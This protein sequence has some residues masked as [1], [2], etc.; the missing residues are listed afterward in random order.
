MFGVIRKRDIFA[1]PFVTVE[2]FGWP[3]FFRVL[4]AGR[5]ETFLSL[6]AGSDGLRPPT[7]EV[8]ELLGHCV[9]LERRARQIY[10]SLAERFTDQ[11]LVRQFFETLAHQEQEHY[12]M[13][14]LCRQLASKGGWLE[15]HFAPWRDAVPRLERQMEDVEDS[16]E[17]LDC[18]ADA[19]RLAIQ[20]EGSEI[21]YVF[22]GAVAATNSRFV[23]TLRAFQTAG[24]KHIAYVFHQIP[25]LEP[26]LAGECRNLR[27]AHLRDMS[28]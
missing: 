14:E 18:V 16:L 12:E 8:P 5:R 13:L 11:E 27:A 3:L 6:L 24:A 2:C 20:I 7:F 1:H 25:K 9:Q 23:K 15:E 22:R 28:G 26:D 10:E 4:I 21:N 19:L 17:D